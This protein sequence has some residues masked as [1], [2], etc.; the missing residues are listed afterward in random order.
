MGTLE[1]ISMRSS[2]RRRLRAALVL[3]AACLSGACSISSGSDVLSVYQ[4]ALQS[5]GNNDSVSLDE[6]ASTPYASMGLRVGDSNE[7]MIVLASDEAGRQ[8]WTSASR[9]AVLTQDGR[10]VRTAGLSFNLGGFELLGDNR[11]ADGSGT[12]RWLAD[13][14]EIDLFGISVVCQDRPEGTEEIDI[15]GKKIPTRRIVERCTADNGDLDWTFKNTFWLDPES[16]F[17]WR[18]IQHVNPRLG[19]LEI[20]I[21]RPPARR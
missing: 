21:L 14:P 6:A 10:I 9:I 4:F 17:V 2:N 1:T 12:F 13:F 19:A 18:S 20:T 15:L 16:N 7:I 11:A 8:L 5:F 3:G